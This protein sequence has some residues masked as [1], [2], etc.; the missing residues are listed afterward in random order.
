MDQALDWLIRLQCA[1]PEDTRAF[2]AW[3][4]PQNFDDAGRQKR[5]LEELRAEIA[6]SAT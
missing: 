2:E 5:R 1:T 4:D 3:L 6:A